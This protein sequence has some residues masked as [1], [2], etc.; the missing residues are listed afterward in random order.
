MI[1]KGDIQNKLVSTDQSG[2]MKRTDTKRM[3]QSVLAGWITAQDEDAGLIR[4]TLRQVMNDP[5]SRQRVDATKAYSQMAGETARVLEVLDKI[6]RLD[7]G[8]ATENIRVVQYVVDK[9]P[10][11]GS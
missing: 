9:G 8:E 1:D 2:G 6:E 11:A 5:D 4:D 3:I 10:D 7:G